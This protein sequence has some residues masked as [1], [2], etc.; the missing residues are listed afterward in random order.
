MRTSLSI[1]LLLFSPC[2]FAQSNTWGVKFSDDISASYTPTINTMT[3]KGWEY[4][5]GIV[6]HGME[7]IYNHTRTTSYINYIKQYVD[8]YVSTNGTVT[9]LGAA[10]DKIQPGV[11]CLFLY[12]ET[13]QTKYKTAATNIRNYLLTGNTFPKT[14][15]GGYWH[16]NT[17]AY[18]NI[19]MLDGIYMA[20]PFLAKYGKMF[21]DTVAV[22]TA[23]FQTLFLAQ[24]TYDSALH[25]CKHAWDYSKTAP[26]ANN[27]NGRSS[28][29]W[30]RAM[31]WYMMAL[32]DII[33]TLPYD[34]PKRQELITLFNNLCIGIQAT[35]DSTTG[36]W[37]QVMDKPDSTDNYIET[38]GSGMFIYALKT[39]VENEWIDS[40]YLQ[41]CKTAWTGLQKYI[42]TYNAR[43]QIQSFAPAMSVQNNYTA[44]VSYPYTAVNCP[45][46][47][48]NTLHPHGY[49]GLLMASSV[50]EF[51]VTTYTFIGNGSWLNAANWEGGNIPPTPLPA[52]NCIIINP[53]GNCILDTEQ[54]IA[55]G[56]S[57]KVL[58]NKS[59]NIQHNLILQ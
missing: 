25:L 38:S 19:M 26:W 57:L 5:N 29:V 12:K 13:G 9:G 55:V 48:G 31:G 56:A 15:D 27:T 34:H 46:P 7:K 20:H 30:S 49:C 45:L 3:N 4:S 33:I 17:L 24:R 6:L 22:N 21:N 32:T 1:L 44:Y 51:P 18:T 2:L 41:V 8:S 47:L 14:P 59:F 39:A 52:A 53:S 10:L 16:K 54:R 40:S 11:L 23:I 37:Y 35:Q 28:E 36:L 42:G 58:K 43:P 50:M